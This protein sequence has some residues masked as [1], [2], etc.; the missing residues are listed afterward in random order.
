MAR[1]AM[2]LTIIK[3]GFV[4][5]S[6]NKAP[7]IEEDS[8]GHCNGQDTRTRPNCQKRAVLLRPF[9]SLS[10]KTGQKQPKSRFRVSTPTGEAAKLGAA[11]RRPGLEHSRQ[12]SRSE[13]LGEK[14]IKARSRD[15]LAS[16]ILAH[17]RRARHQRDAARPP[18]TL[19]LADP[20][21]RRVA[22][23]AR[24]LEVHEHAVK[25]RS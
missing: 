23:E 20:G 17:G 10:K 12:R 19:V 15:G 18:R 22:V 16:H 25:R 4:D 5:L 14:H 21:C 7:T 8:R 24:H 9:K 13:R 2:A 3:L 1:M 11:R 6:A